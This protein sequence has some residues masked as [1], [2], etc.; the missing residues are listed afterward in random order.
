MC[1]LDV[2]SCSAGAANACEAVC[3]DDPLKQLR[4]LSESAVSAA[5]A[6]QDESRCHEDALQ[7]PTR[8]Y[9]LVRSLLPEQ[10]LSDAQDH[11]A[12]LT[13]VF[14]KEGG[15][16]YRDFTSRTALQASSAGL[17]GALDGVLSKWDSQGLL[18]H[19][20]D[21]SRAAY[22]LSQPLRVGGGQHISIDAELAF[23]KC[24]NNCL[25]DWHLDGS[26]HLGS[27]IHKFWVMLQKDAAQESRGHS[28]I[29]LAS[30][31]RL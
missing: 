27:R 31:R 11:Y 29:V 18:P 28:N 17:P 23:A 15:R 22:E 14:K 5:L 2:G 6:A 10:T 12:T 4:R 8:G 26:G 30:L 19:S 1:E 9:A 13:K 3:N 7:L 20:S 21:P 25:G 24:G 16:V